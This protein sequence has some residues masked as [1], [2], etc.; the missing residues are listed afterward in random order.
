MLRRLRLLSF[1]LC[2]LLLAGRSSAASA[3]EPTQADTSAF[4]GSWIGTLE[5]GP[6][7]FRVVFTLEQT[8]ERL[9]GTMASPDQG[10][11]DIPIRDILIAADTVRIGVPSIAGQFAGV[12]D[13]SRD[14]ISGRWVQGPSQFPL[15]LTRTE[16]V[17]SV[18][19]PQ[20]PTP[21]YPYATET[22]AFSAD[23]TRLEGTL[24]RPTQDAPAPAVVLVAGA[25]PHDRDGTRHGHKPLH[26][27]ADHLTRQGIAVFRF[28]ERG[29][30]ASEGT[31]RGATF[32]TLADDV[33]AALHA[34]AAR[35]GIDATRIGIVGHSEGGVIA[36]LAATQTDRDAFLVLLS[37]PGVTGAEILTQQ[38]DQRARAR[39]LDRRTR[40]LQRGTQQRIFETLQADTDSAAIAQ[41]LKSIMEGATGIYGEQM[42]QREIRRLMQPW[43][44]FFITHDPVTALKDAGVPV[45]AVY[46]AND[47]RL[48][49]P[50]N[51]AAIQEA[52]G[53]TESPLTLR[54]L[55]GLNHLLQT[56]P[57]NA[58]SAYGA[59]SETL[60]PQALTLISDWIREQTR[61]QP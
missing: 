59:I 23:G 19:R 16:A 36:P 44:R 43:L 34:V 7:S 14:T 61:P 58:P 47:Q 28:D 21:P 40:S 56:A 32:A 3:F 35:P 30:G 52:L 60:A 29:V 33:A 6:Q 31:Q 54:T 27:L 15:T 49:P 41:N 37:A 20:Q 38:L 57:A 53:A 39:G 17:P 1:I 5:V 48:A 22:L 4:M 45:L 9:A 51:A 42:I 46:G 11:A 2:T 26:V 24:T 25:G 13:A 50:T 10:I 12:L 55:D 18:Q 8:A